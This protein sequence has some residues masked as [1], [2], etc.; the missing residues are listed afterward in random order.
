M[1]RNIPFSPPDI[2]NREIELVTEV[3]K[4]GWLTTGPKTKEFE[5][6]LAAYLGTDKTVCLNSATAA[7]ELA[8]RVLG[9]GEGDEVIVPAYTYTAS[10]SVIE[11][12]GA[13][14]VLV[15][16][17]ENHYEMNYDL[18]EQ[19]ITP[20]TKVI[21]P[22]ELGGV[23]CDYTRIFEVVEKKKDLF[24]ANNALQARFNRIIVVSY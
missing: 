10:C 17:Q 4:S 16:I 5:R 12:V 8:L 11:H 21:I 22:V 7:L 1:I 20:A 18:L 19:A 6:Q 13:T 3:L 14:P 9:I 2:S 15:D 23:P 24:S